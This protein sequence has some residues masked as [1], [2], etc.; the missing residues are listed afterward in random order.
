MA[1]A[2]PYS[3]TLWDVAEQMTRD[4]IEHQQLAMLQKQLHYVETHSAYYQQ[5]FAQTG[6]RAADLRV[7]EDIRK[8]PLTRKSDYV[9]ALETHAPF[10][11]MCAADRSDLVRVHFSSGT[12]GKPTPVYWTQKDVAGWTDL[13]AR[14]FYAQGMRAGD[15]FQCMFNYAWFVAGLGATYAAE[16]IGA[17]VIPASAGDTQRQITTMQD[18]GTQILAATPSFLAHLAET[19]LTMGIDPRDLKVRALGTGGEPGASIPATRQRLESIWGAD[20]YDC[21]GAL[22]CQ[23]IAWESACKEGPVLAEDFIY[24]EVLDPDTEQPVEDG[25]PGVLV[26][27]HLRKE[28]CPLVRWW[29]GDVV[30]R[31]RRPASDGRTHARLVG[32][33]LG[34]ADDMLIVRGVNVFPSAIE[35]VIRMLPDAGD[36]FIIDL[37]QSPRGASHGF[38]EGLLIKIETHSEDP[39]QFASN[40]AAILRDHLKVRCQVEALP[41]GSLPRYTH[42]AKRVVRPENGAL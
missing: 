28:A 5:I 18:F 24:A 34:R 2:T 6:F 1:T 4:Q 23:P 36:E 9:Q 11:A 12:T 7:L 16:R 41:A 25:T 37:A 35:N 19:A 32:G 8:L 42:K 38:L 33:V 13:Y 10:G 14:Y 15:I 31:D 21:Y 27:T 22:E 20:M 29:T 39:A 40:A 26:I 17:L 3:A 30:I